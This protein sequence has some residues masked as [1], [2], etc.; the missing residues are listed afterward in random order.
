MKKYMDKFMKNIHINKNL[1][2]FLLVIVI[3]GIASGAL[4][5]LVIDNNDKELV[6][7]YL[8]DFFNNIKK[9]QLN[10]NNSFVNSL[11]FTILFGVLI[12]LLGISVI[13]FFIVLFMLFLKS[14]ILGFSVGSIIY[15]FKFKGILYSLVYVFPHQVINILIF[16]LLSGYALIV[17]FKIIRCFSSKKTLDFRNIFNRYMRVLI[18]S[19]LILIITSLYEIYL[20]PKLLNILVSFLK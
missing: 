20:M 9:G 7:N 3:V 10:F 4:F 12:W 14:F 1:F 15:V 19:V 18:F 11:F 16:M 13:G 8:T 6:Y 2:I 5:S 17:S